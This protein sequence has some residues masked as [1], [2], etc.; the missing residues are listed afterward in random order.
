MTSFLL[1]FGFSYYANNKLE[2]KYEKQQKRAK[3][4]FN[5]KL[6]MHSPV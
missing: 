3:L 4:V 6:G 1:C 5:T 2:H